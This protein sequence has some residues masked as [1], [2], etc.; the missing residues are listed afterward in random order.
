MKLPFRFVGRTIR[1]IDSKEGMRS[2]LA[3]EKIGQ[4]HFAE[5][6][7]AQLCYYDIRKMERSKRD[8]W[9]KGLLKK[10]SSS[11]IRFKNPTS[12]WRLKLICSNRKSSPSRFLY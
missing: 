1:D 9:I 10:S 8:E 11:D 5:F 7:S 2:G 12:L 4:E 3:L 6:D